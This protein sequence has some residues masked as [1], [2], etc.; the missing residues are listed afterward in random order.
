MF[1]LVFCEGKFA[2]RKVLAGGV[3]GRTARS[4]RD[5]G[6]NK[7]FRVDPEFQKLSFT[8]NGFSSVGIPMD[9]D[10]EILIAIQ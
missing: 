5:L 8:D 7:L 9:E 1:L 6:R 2:A 4:A 10:L 3:A